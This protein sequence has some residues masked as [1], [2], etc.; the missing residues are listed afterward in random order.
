MISA[1]N[2]VFL[3]LRPPPLKRWHSI[4]NETVHSNKALPQPFIIISKNHSMI[5]CIWITP[6]SSSSSYSSSSSHPASAASASSAAA[7]SLRYS[8]GGSAP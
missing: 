2:V 3:K 7:K 4:F 1:R 8:A 5:Y 6:S